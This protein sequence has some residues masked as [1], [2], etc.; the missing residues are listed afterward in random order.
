MTR[1]VLPLLV[2]PTI[3]LASSPGDSFAL[4]K[5][6]I[7]KSKPEKPDAPVKFENSPFSGHIYPYF[8]GVDVKAIFLAMATSAQ[9]ESDAGKLAR[10]QSSG[11]QVANGPVIPG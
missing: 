3:V 9:T 6:H 5:N 11:P 10:V 2:L 1:W 4:L 7:W 8:K